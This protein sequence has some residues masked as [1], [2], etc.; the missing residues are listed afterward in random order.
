MVPFQDGVRDPLAQGTQVEEKK[1]RLKVSEQKLERPR[2]G[3]GGS[4]GVLTLA[5]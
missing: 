3:R 2:S 4:E 1:E 5:K